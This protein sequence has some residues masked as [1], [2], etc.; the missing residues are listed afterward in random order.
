MGLDV[1]YD[2]EQHYADSRTGIPSEPREYLQ[3]LIR[4]GRLGV[5]NGRG[6]YNYEDKA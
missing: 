3:K 5:K 6:F 2:I 4:E 1:V